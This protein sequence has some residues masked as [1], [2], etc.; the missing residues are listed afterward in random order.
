MSVSLTKPWAFQGQELHLS[1][2][3]LLQYPYLSFYWYI[4]DDLG[5]SWGLN[6]SGRKEEYI[7]GKERKQIS[8]AE[9]K[10]QR[11]GVSACVPFTHVLMDWNRLRHQSNRKM[12]VWV[13]LSQS[14]HM[15]HTQQCSHTALI[16]AN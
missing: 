10:E 5:K 12:T 14:Q 4:F 8:K 7:K 2:L 11:D 15:L 6:K 9:I 16:P 1:H 3:C 13:S